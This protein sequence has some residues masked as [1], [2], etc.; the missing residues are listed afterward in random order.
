MKF[1]ATSAT[2]RSLSTREVEEASA[3]DPEIVEV[4]K[5]ITNGIIE[6]CKSYA[7]IANELCVVG[8]IVLRGNCIVLPQSLHARALELAH[9]GHLG[10]VGTKQHLRTKVWWPGMDKAAEKYCKTCHGCQIVARPDPTEP[11]RT[12]PLPDRPGRILQ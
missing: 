5:A 8:Y 1:V 12:T 10:I 4:R 9:E 7:P 11:L 6:N 3:T 2:S